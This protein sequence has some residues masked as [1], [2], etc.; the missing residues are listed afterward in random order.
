V[1]SLP[2]PS[3]ELSLFF[4]RH[5]SSGDRET[6]AIGKLDH[7]TKQVPARTGLSEHIVDRVL[8]SGFGAPYP[9]V[10]ETYFFNL[11]RSHAVSADMINPILLPKQLIN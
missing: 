11:F 6:F 8:A 9:S 3:L 1:L 2:F 4:L 5:G 7:N 10:T